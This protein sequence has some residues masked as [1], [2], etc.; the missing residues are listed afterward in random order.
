MTIQVD[1][2][3]KLS[4]TAA[5]PDASQE[6]SSGLD[7]Y[8][9]LGRSGLRVSPL[10]LG[11]TGIGNASGYGSSTAES[12]LIFDT[13]VDRGGN[14]IDT[15]NIYNAGESETLI[16]EFA[17]GRRNRLVI[18]TKYGGSLDGGASNANGAGSQ[19]KNMRISVEESLRRLNTDYI[20]L[21][22]LHAWDGFT[23]PDE[24]MRSFDDLISAGKILHAGISN[25]PA[26]VI[27][28]LQT[29]ADFMGWAP[30]VSMEIEY[31]LV[32]R[33][34]DRELLPMARGLGLASVG[35]RTVGGGALSGKYG[36]AKPP[37]SPE[38]EAR[39]P[40]GFLTSPLDA[41]TLRIADVVAEIA[42]EMGRTSPEVALAWALAKITVPIMGV[43]SIKQLL[44]NLGALT[45]TLDSQ[46]MQK[47]EAV[48][49][50]DVGYP[51]AF[52][53]LPA[54]RDVFVGRRPIRSRH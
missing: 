54:I 51:H 24:I 37:P 3:G 5:Q 44:G 6:K 29:I 35:W 18:A 16:G 30:L 19:R 38:Q 36:T 41:R 39:R 11:G 10:A 9:L 34:G 23:H 8:R 42:Q 25:T 48:S 46:Q 28:R 7:N 14:F 31:S 22:Y 20:D 17:T 52:M 43:T 13:Y 50:N 45:I 32:L 15:G 49:S 12:R 21:L 1:S 33:D 4:A 2:T 53:A 40:Q 27:C 26:W 47:L